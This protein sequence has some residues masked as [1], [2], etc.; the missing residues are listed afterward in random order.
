MRLTWE[1]FLQKK[2]KKKNVVRKCLQRRLSH[3]LRQNEENKE[4]RML[5]YRTSIITARYRRTCIE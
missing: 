3:T 2:E 5:V 4:T 1:S